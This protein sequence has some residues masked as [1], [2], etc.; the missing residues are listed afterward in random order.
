M[1]LIES[2]VTILLINFSLNWHDSMRDYGC[3]KPDLRIP[4]KLVEISELLKMKNLVS[5]QQK[6]RFS[7]VLLKSWRDN[8]SEDK[9]MNILNLSLSWVKV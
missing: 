5:V 9:L 6:R 8:L 1:V 7:I 4:L 2:F 3:D